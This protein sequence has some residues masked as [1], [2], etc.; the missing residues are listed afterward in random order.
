MARL[1]TDDALAAQLGAGARE[2]VYQE[3][4]PDRHLLQYERLLA[5]MP[6]VGDGPRS[7]EAR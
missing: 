4:L 3:F 1:L 5:S 2:R 6:L 7:P